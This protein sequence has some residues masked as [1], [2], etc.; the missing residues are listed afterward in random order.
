MHAVQPLVL[1]V[2]DEEDDKH[3]SND[4]ACVRKKTPDTLFVLHNSQILPVEIK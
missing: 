1:L 4:D 2:D 3:H